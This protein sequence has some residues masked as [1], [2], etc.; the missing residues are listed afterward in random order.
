[1]SAETGNERTALSA[2]HPMIAVPNAIRIVLRETARRLVTDV[3]RECRKVDD[4]RGSFAPTVV[5]EILAKD[6][7]MQEPGYPPYRASIMDG[8]CIRSNEAFSVGDDWTHKVIEKIYAGDEMRKDG[9]TAASSYSQ[10]EL[11]S[12]Y[13]VTTGAR[14]P[15]SFDC[16]VPIEDILVDTDGARIAIRQLPAMHGKWIRP[17]GCDI[18]PGSIVL[19][20][21]HKMDPVSLGLWKQSGSRTIELRS[22]VKVGVLSTGNEIKS[23]VDWDLLEDG[24]QGRIP[25]VNRPILCNLLQNLGICNVIDL[26]ACRDDDPVTVAKI[27]REALE[28]CEVILTTGGIS[29]GESDIVEDV[30]RGLG[31]TLH[32]G[33]IHMKP[34]KPS[35]FVSIPSDTGATRFIFSL[36]GNPVSAVVCGH[37]LAR[38]CLQLLYEGADESP[39][40]H[41]ESINEWISRIVEN[42]SLSPP[43]ILAQL[44]HDIRLDPER[45]EYHRVCLEFH[46]E[47][48]VWIATS[49]GVQQSSRLM[50]LRDAHALL[51][52]PQGSLRRP[53]AVAGETFPALLL[54]EKLAHRSTVSQSQHLNKKLSR[55]FGV[56]IIHMDEEKLPNI[57]DRVKN[58]LS[59][60]IS[61]S[62]G[63]SSSRTFGGP[64]ESLYAFVAED[65]VSDFV[66]VIGSN[67]KGSFAKNAAASTHLRGHL[68]KVAEAIALQLRRGASSQSPTAALFETTVGLVRGDPVSLLVFVPSEGLDSGLSNVRGL[69]KH[70]LE[71]ARDS[72]NHAH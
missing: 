29:M 65:G 20:S 35:Q 16:V 40:T 57:E 9:S 72:R 58:A 33:R 62:V 25:D 67:Q 13:Y 6:V 14:V 27:I 51:A 31:G 41:G 52:L 59:G 55:S 11:P 15:H 43:E 42:S 10:D 3:P 56:G 5:G 46:K 68:G 44:G 4:D 64:I 18:P 47:K 22:K 48:N 17:V 71:I 30:I 53:N 66:V 60:S 61:G 24:A 63:I 70:A 45:P 23:S 49:T 26:G 54:N 37:L 19:P 69:L 8:Y 50:S 32:F 12:A 39:D 34:G 1:M 28:T 36:P 7:L 21:G 2:V 38:P